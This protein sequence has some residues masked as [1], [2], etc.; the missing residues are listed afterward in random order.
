AVG[1]RSAGRTLARVLERLPAKPLWIVTNPD[2]L[3]LLCTARYALS[4]QLWSR[5]GACSSLVLDEFHLYRGPTLVRALVLTQ[6]LRLLLGAARVR[7]LTATLA[8]HVRDLLVGRLAFASVSAPPAKEGRVVQHPVNL[9]V[10]TATGDNATTWITQTASALRSKLR[11]EQ[12][13][14][15]VPLLVLRQ[16]VFATMAL[17]DQLVTAG[18]DR[19]EIGIYRGLTSKAIRSVDGKT[20]VVGTSTLEVGVDFKTTRLFFEALSSQAFAQR[21]GR[22]GRHSAG[23]ATFL[24]DARVAS[25]LTGLGHGVHPRESLFSTVSRLLPLDNDLQGFVTSEYGRCVVDAAFE[26]LETRGRELRAP[27]VFFQKVDSARLAFVT[28]V[29]MAAPPSS[30]RISRAARRRLAAAISFRGGA[31]S[32]E[33]FDRRERQRRGADDLAHYDIELPQ[34][35]RRAEW[36]GSPKPGACPIIVGFRKPRSLALS[37]RM[38][39]AVQT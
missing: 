31:G 37:L 12:A 9:T 19:P 14:D 22:V 23:T 13:P 34:F 2:S 15:S 32:V 5:L 33:V 16:S 29:G 8:E 35:Y 6:L 28:R 20:I 39:T 1:G 4:P 27:D 25:G 38:A 11:T 17:E 10:V 7:V 36:V 26:A 3:Y 21:L 24:T 30:D 18:F